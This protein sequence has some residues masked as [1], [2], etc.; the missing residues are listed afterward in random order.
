MQSCATAFPSNLHITH[1]DT[2]KMA[3]RKSKADPEDLPDAPDKSK[4]QDDDDSGSDEVCAYHPFP[5]NA[6]TNS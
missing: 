2:H 4:K 1:I 5:R 6:L 3:K